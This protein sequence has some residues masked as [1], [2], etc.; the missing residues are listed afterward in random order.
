MSK[1][2]ELSSALEECLAQ[3]STANGYHTALQGIYGFGKTKK[4]GD[5]L[6]CLLVRIADDTAEERAGPSAKRLATYQIEGVFPRSASL[7]DLQRCHHDILRALG[8]GHPVANRA[9][10]AGAVVDDSAEFDPEPEG[11]LRRVITSLSLRYVE[12]Y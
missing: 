4:D 10:V 9:L 12:A 3:I 11:T 6:P 7:Q 8:Y 2:A 5:P 1:A